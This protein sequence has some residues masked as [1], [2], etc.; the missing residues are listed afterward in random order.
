MRYG[1]NNCEQTNAVSRH[2]SILQYAHDSTCSLLVRSFFLFSFVEW[3][4]RKYVSGYKGSCVQ[5]GGW[6]AARVYSQGIPTDIAFNNIRSTIANGLEGN[7]DGA[8][9]SGTKQ[10]RMAFQ[11]ALHELYSQW[12][13]FFLVYYSY[14]LDNE[15]CLRNGTVF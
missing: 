1:Y 11:S 6:I 5:A 2:I 10:R 3:K 7:C 14:R 8:L 4:W 12:R 15:L 9:R 13:L